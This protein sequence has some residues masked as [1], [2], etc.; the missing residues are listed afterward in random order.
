[1]ISKAVRTNRGF[2]LIELLIGLAIIGLIMGLVVS[3]MGKLFE[4]EMKNSAS[5]LASTIR[6]IYNKSISE[7]VTL[8]LVFDLDEQKYWVESTSAEHF[9]LKKE[10][11]EDQTPKKKTE[12]KEEKGKKKEEKKEAGS[13]SITPKEATFTKEESS[14]LKAVQLPKGVYFKDIYAEHQ[15]AHLSEGQAYIYFFPQ[16]YV[17]RSVINLRDKEDAV[18]Y[19]LTLNP[20]TGAVVIERGYKE[21]EV[22]R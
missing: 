14:L 12:K 7:G 2:T 5:H 17:E 9:A 19:S 1:M 13:E 16:G 18:H 10:G 22:E 4:R 20:I 8:R 21:A 11:E 15:T 3:K 6:Y